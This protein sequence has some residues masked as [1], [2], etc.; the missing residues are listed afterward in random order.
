V[1]QAQGTLVSLY[2]CTLEQARAL[3]E[4]AS[5]DEVRSLEQIADTVLSTLGPDQ[6]DPAEQDAGEWDATDAS[7]PP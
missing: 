1:A 5:E 3:L 7:G 6:L 4:N 2:E